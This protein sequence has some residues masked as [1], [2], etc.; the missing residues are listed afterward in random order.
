MSQILLLIQLWSTVPTPS[1]QPD[2]GVITISDEC[3][4]E[5]SKCPELGLQPKASNE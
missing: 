3:K 1:L 4:A 2:D 5:P